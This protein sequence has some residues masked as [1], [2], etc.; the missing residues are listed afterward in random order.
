MGRW[1]NYLLI[2]TEQSFNRQAIVNGKFVIEKVIAY[3]YDLIGLF[4]SAVVTHVGGNGRFRFVLDGKEYA[5][6]FVKNIAAE[7]EGSN[8][9]KDPDKYYDYSNV[10]FDRDIIKDWSALYMYNASKEYW[11]PIELVKFSG[12]AKEYREKFPK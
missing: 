11:K 8:V 1:I 5:T 9:L 10:I 7:Y 2:M 12:T 3:S 6:A 4:G